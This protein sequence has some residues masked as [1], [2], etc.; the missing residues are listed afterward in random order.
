MENQLEKAEK[1]NAQIN[2]GMEKPYGVPAELAEH[3]RAD[4]DKSTFMTFLLFTAV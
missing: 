2:P 4:R 1:D 3:R